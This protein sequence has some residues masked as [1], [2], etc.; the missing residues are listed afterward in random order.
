[1]SSGAAGR[2]T[3][4][5]Q[6]VLVAGSLNMDYHLTVEKEPVD[7]GSVRV[8]GLLVTGGGHAGNCAVALSALGCR[9]SLFSA[10]GDDAE[11]ASLR[12]ELEQQGVRHDHVV[13]VAGATTGR[14]FIPSYPGHRSMLMY[15]GATE[16]WRRETCASL[17][18]SRFRTVVLFDP[19]KDVAQE[20]VAA[21][22]AA[23][24]PVHWTPGGLHAGA[25]W[26]VRLAARCHRVYVNR[27]EFTDM[28]DAPPEA[29]HILRACRQHGLSGLVVTLG[30]RGALASDGR[31][32]W[33]TDAAEVTA[34]DSTGAG[35]AF[36]AGA[37][38]AELLGHGWPLA[39]AWGA[40]AGAH[41]VTVPGARDTSLS[42]D[43]LPAAA[44]AVRA[45]S[46]MPESEE[47]TTP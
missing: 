35:D 22:G 32:V 27:A 17:P 42:L 38:A 24:M 25:P 47:R 12:T 1:M 2:N 4:R 21:A 11:G 45:G 10:V 3:L 37:V 6:E 43:R 30:S 16:E 34:T 46:F 44:A 33:F 39:L 14:V 9:V 26:A 5:D 40:A 28:F 19:P 7:D 36:T 23:G 20:L 31:T 13:A 18:L 29:D 41:A 8:T 15:R